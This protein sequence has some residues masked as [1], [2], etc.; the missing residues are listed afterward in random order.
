MIKRALGIAFVLAVGLSLTAFTLGTFNQPARVRWHV[1]SSGAQPAKGTILPSAY[2]ASTS[3]FGT[4]PYGLAA[5]RAGGIQCFWAGA[6]ATDGGTNN[7]ELDIIHEDGGVDCACGFDA[8]SC[9]TSMAEFDCDCPAGMVQMGGS[10][11][12]LQVSQSSSC[13]TQPGQLECDVDL[14]R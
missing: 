2:R 9:V 11:W 7:Y 14:F 3:P 4:V 8:G 13:A 12:N 10:Q 5:W 1:S 6:G